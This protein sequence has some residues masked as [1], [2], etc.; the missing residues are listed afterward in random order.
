MSVLA[1]AAG[2]AAQQLVQVVGALFVLSAFAAAQF[3]MTTTKGRGYLLLNLVGSVTLAVLAA[4]GEQYGFLLLE[5]VWA[6]VS[7]WAL[8]AGLRARKRPLRHLRGRPEAMFAVMS[9]RR[10]VTGRIRGRMGDMRRA[11]AWR[12]DPPAPVAEP[13]EDLGED[14]EAAYA[15]AQPFTMTSRERMFA[16]WQAATYVADADVPGDVVECGVWRGGSSMLAAIALLRSGAPRPLWMYDTFEGMTVPSDRDRRWDGE[17]AADQFATHLRDDGT[18]GWAHASL[19]DVRAQMSSSG[20]PADAVRYVKGPV[21]QTI[22]EQAPETISL[23]RLDTDWYES[24]RHE[25]THLWPRLSPGGILVI[26]D[27]GHWQ[28]ARQAVDEYFAAQDV[29]LLLHRIDYTGRI[30]IKP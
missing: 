13:E 16:L 20:Y 8:L 18:S 27:Y 30:A 17:R 26:D 23:L 2:G 5:G 25:L 7:A 21:E 22:P 6:L 1:S 3:G 11:V 19:E 9:A 10:A 28:G 4:D 15:R 14:F 24:T 12:L 29:V